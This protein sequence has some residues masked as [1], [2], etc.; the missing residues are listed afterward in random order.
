M[1]SIT[2]NYGIY[3]IK[4]NLVSRSRVTEDL[5]SKG[6][7]FLNENKFKEALDCYNKSINS[8]PEQIK[9]YKKIAKAQFGLKNYKEAEKNYKTYLK[10][11]P[12]DI[13]IIIELGETQRQMGHFKEALN[14]F[15]KAYELDNAN[16]LARRSIFMTKNNILSIFSPQRAEREKTEYA[17][18]NLEEAL[19]MTINYL[20]PK[21]MNEFKNVTFQFGKTSKMGGTE[22]IA[23]Y[24]NSKNTITISNSYIYA[25]PQVIAAYLSHES[26]HAHDNDAY[27]S[28]T[29]EQDAYEIATKFWIKNSNGIKDPEM[30]Y[31]AELYKKSPETLKTRVAEI[32]SL[33]DPDISLTSPNHPPQKLFHLSSSNNHHVASQSIKS[34]DV[35]A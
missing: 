34:Y 20:T 18:K 8:N 6:D 19:N 4:S 14:T 17:Q 23:Q 30:D 26:V 10:E 21:Y 31:A 28:I 13:D 5:N 25:S 16:D 3:N 11:K 7:K 22:N 24:E 15:E 12:E 2:P 32:Y 35:I 29:E 9:V 27:T 1:I 33:R